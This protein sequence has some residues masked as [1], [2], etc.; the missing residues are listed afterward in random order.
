ML[1]QVHGLTRRF[2]G[3]V[4]I[5]GVDMSVVSGEIRAVIGPNGAGKTTF[6]NLVTGVYRPSAGRIKFD[7]RSL[8]GLRPSAITAA[9]VARTFQHPALFEG[10]NVR[11]NVAVAAYT[12]HPRSLWRDFISFRHSSRGAQETRDVAMRW[13]DF[14]G[15]ARKASS[16]V[17]ALTPAERRLLELARAMATRPRLLL[18]DEPFAGMTSEEAQ[19]LFNRVAELRKQGTTIL[20][21][22]H[23]MR[24]V[25]K[26]ADSVTVLSFGRK[27][28]EGTPA[29]VQASDA[30]I[31][32][33][34]GRE[35]AAVVA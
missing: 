6:L 2:G 1:F 16:D 26:L 35:S 8:V 20:L 18:L 31:E 9:G 23:N 12:H 24:L 34:L 29:Q 10:L 27:I 5:D 14:V 15:L 17:G 32:A 7:G 22:D 13:L 33:Y 21:I 3:L 4:A 19:T 30:V 11:D 28:G 25:M